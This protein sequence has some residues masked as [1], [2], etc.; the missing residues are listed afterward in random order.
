MFD[1]TDTVIQN[2]ETSD[3]TFKF[4]GLLNFEYYKVDVAAYSGTTLVFNVNVSDVNAMLVLVG[5]LGCFV[6]GTAI[7][8]ADNVWK[9]IEDIQIG[10]MV[11]SKGSKAH[12]VTNILHDSIPADDVKCPYIIE[13]NDVIFKPRRR[14]LVSP[15][16]ALWHSSKRK[17]IEAKNIKHLKKCMKLPNNMI[18]YYNLEINHEREDP[19]KF[20]FIAEGIISESWGERSSL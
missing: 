15:N 13:K 12:P 14:V 11:L 3:K 9:A 20:P 17:F 2:I 19:F 4:T 1:S 16:H 6:K 5:V 8:M 18:E 10:D 7:L